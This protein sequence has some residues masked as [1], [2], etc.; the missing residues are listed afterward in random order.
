MK[1]EHLKWVLGVLLLGALVLGCAQPQAPKETTTPQATATTPSLPPGTVLKVGG[2]PVGGLWYPAASLYAQLIT[3]NTPYKA[4]PTVGGGEENVRK[5]VNNQLDLAITFSLPTYQAYNGKG[6]FDKPYK[7]IRTIAA[8]Y[9]SPLQVAVL[10]DS[11]IH[12]YSDL[13]GKRVSPGKVGFTGKYTFEKVLEVYG[14]SLDDIE[15]A[16]G[17]ITYAGYRDQVDLMKDGHLDAIVQQTV[18]PSSTLLDLSTLKPI[19][20]LSIDQ[21]KL[22]E[23]LKRNPAYSAYEIPANVYNGQTEPVQSVGLWNIWVCR[24]DLPED[25]VYKITKILWDNQEKFYELHQAYRDNMK[26]ENALKGLTVPLHPGAY[27]FYKEKGL[28]IPDNLVPP[29]Y[30]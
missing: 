4:T 24:A 18:V 29:E 9:P 3:D 12:S 25:V 17:K 16:G 8:V 1:K 28:E 13:L 22:E 6:N 20:L 11:D 10:A 21:D 15:K 27:K 19:R 5:I 2:G 23:F 7:N 14:I 26:L 30:R